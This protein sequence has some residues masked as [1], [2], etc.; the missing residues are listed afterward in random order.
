MHFQIRCALVNTVVKTGCIKPEHEII[1]SVIVNSLHML[2]YLMFN[3][4]FIIKKLYAARLI[5]SL[6]PF[7]IISSISDFYTGSYSFQSQ[8]AVYNIPCLPEI[9]YAF[10]HSSYFI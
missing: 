5:S 7:H 4:F 10:D 9:Y 2:P 3:I 1:I 8:S 6:G